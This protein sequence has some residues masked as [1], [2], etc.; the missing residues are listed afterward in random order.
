MSRNI[1]SKDIR[2]PGIVI[3]R[4]NYGEADRI[5]T[6]ITPS[7]KIS[8]IAKGVRKAK[9]KLAG[10][11][12]MLTLAD[13]NLHEGRGE[14]YTVTGAKMVEHYEKIL[15]DYEKTV[16]VG[17]IL[18]RV[19]RA[20]RLEDERYF[21]ITRACLSEL[22]KGEI[23][24]ELVEAWFLLNFTQV[25]EPINL[26]RDVGGE[27]LVVDA[28]YEWD[29]GEKAFRKEENGK[30]GVEEIKFLR[31]AITADLVIVKRVRA[32]E[33]MIGR[34]LEFARIIGV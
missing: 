3:K 26:Y 34:I 28:R 7:G 22:A 31:I 25:T 23:N 11:A 29:V 13:I 24:D 10:G 9:S 20:E 12:E 19:A 33:E 17:N 1:Q 5:L 16:L 6:I 27:K 8:A 15:K 32:G 21:L 2:T 14:M 30:Y 18:K 4:V